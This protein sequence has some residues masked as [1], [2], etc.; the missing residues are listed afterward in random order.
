MLLTIVILNELVRNA[1][2][3]LNEVR[4]HI[5]IIILDVVVIV[6]IIISLVIVHVIVV[7]SFCFAIAT[8]EVQLHYL[9]WVVRTFIY[10]VFSF[11]KCLLFHFRS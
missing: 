7:T 9:R 4:S 5:I 2:C 1:T 3:V 11:N 8:T 6:T 10:V